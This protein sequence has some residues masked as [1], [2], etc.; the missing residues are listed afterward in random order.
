MS[1]RSSNTTVDKDSVNKD[2]IQIPKCFTK[3][4]PFAFLEHIQTVVEHYKS[5]GYKKELAQER[6]VLRPNGDEPV[7]SKTAPTKPTIANGLLVET[8]DENG[9][10]ITGSVSS[11]AHAKKEYTDALA[12][13][14]DDEKLFKSIHTRWLESDKIAQDCHHLLMLL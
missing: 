14:L 10:Q 1:P 2:G 4:A 13:F 11:N 3:H 8:L 12:E 6:L 7:F 5:M 9:I